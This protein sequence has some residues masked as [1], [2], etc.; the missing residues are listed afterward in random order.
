MARKNKAKA[1]VENPSDQIELF[2]RR[3][4]ELWET[5]AIKQGFSI[6]YNFRWT[7][8]DNNLAIKSKE[9]DIDDLRSFLTVF[10]KFISNDSPIYLPTIFNICHKHISNLECRE[11]LADARQYWN[12]LS[13]GKE[14]GI[15][16]TI[17]SKNY[18]TLEL[19]YLWINGHY[20]HDDVDK[21]RII[22]S[23]EPYLLTATRMLFL[24]FVIETMQVISNLI[25]N[26]RVAKKRDWFTFENKPSE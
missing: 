22:N 7:A 15:A 26:I 8:D 10:R 21:M 1:T 17:N 14:I 23:I 9:P 13:Q 20:F 12:E 5:R 18:T 3:G 11:A 2:L 19:V 24:D 4:K 25:R 16:V 6:S